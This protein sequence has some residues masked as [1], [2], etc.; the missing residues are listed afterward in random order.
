MII[1]FVGRNGQ[2]KSKN[3]ALCYLC[4][5]FAM[6]SRLFIAASWSLAGKGLTSWLLF[7]LSSCD[8]VTFPCPDILGQVWYLTALIPDHC[9]LSYFGIRGIDYIKLK[10]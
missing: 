10:L 2:C 9:Q 6:L 8:C 1:V 7:V 3:E 5:V 4:L